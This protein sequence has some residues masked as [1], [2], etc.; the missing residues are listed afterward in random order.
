MLK[1]IM[2]L[3]FGWLFLSAVRL[4]FKAA[5][6]LTKLIAIVLMVAAFP[7]LVGVLMI[8]GGFVLLLPVVLIG[9]A[10]LLLKA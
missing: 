10:V 4:L 6:G 5:W 9:G 3:L 7:V 1:I 8:A 2:I